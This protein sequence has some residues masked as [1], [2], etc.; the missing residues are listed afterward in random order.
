[1]VPRLDTGPVKMI[2]VSQIVLAGVPQHRQRLNL[3][4]QTGKL[5]N[6][7]D[8]Y[9]GEDFCLQMERT[10]KFRSSLAS[11]T[12]SI[13][14]TK[15]V[16]LNPFNKLKLSNGARKLLNTPNAGG[17]SV[18]SEVLSLEFMSR[19]FG[20]KLLKTEMEVQYWPIGGSITDYVASIYG[21]IIGVSVTRAMKYDGEFA[22]EDAIRLLNK[23]L[24][25]VNQST[26]NNQ[27]GWKKQVLHVWATSTETAH[28]VLRA[29]NLLDDF[30]RSDTVV[31][32]TVCT[33]DPGLFYERK[34]G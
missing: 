22:I 32:V 21:Q 33:K 28:C 4:C 5:L 20:A 16:T 18:I 23:K 25:G 17:S 12:G 14:S 7:S 31:L 34:A 6:A 13:V 1:M 2:A 29:W 9:I 8:Y 3:I 24:R 11:S 19:F 30:V 27:E 26:A 15:I 10:Y